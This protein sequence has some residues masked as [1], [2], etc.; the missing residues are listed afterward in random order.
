MSSKIEKTEEY[1][2]RDGLDSTKA[3]YKNRNRCNWPDTFR[4]LAWMIGTWIYTSAWFAL[5]FYAWIIDTRS[6]FIV[7]IVLWGCFV[8]MML[9]VF[10]IPNLMKFYREEAKKQKELDEEERIKQERIREA[11][12]N[13]QGAIDNLNNNNNNN[14]IND[15]NNDNNNNNNDNNNNQD[16]GDNNALNEDDEKNLS[17]GTKNKPNENLVTEKPLIVNDK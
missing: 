3:V 10:F 11:I 1:D 9:F 17:H 15:N 8:A 13:A 6:T 7:L 16:K 12:A 5:F 2:F 14:N 4:Y